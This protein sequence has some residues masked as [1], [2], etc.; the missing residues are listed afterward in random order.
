MPDLRACVGYGILRPNGS[1][2]NAMY[3]LLA[4][5]VILAEIDTG[6]TWKIGGSEICKY[7]EE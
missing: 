7:A 3:L 2:F 6:V 4:T 1:G 5:C